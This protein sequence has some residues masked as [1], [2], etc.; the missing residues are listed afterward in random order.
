MKPNL[1]IVGAPKCGTTAWYEYLRGHPD[2]FL[3]DRKEPHYFCTDFPD[4]RRI[5]TERDYLG[6]FAEATSQPIAGEASAS[7]L[8]SKEAARNLR[9]FK[10][11]AKI[12]IF[13][14]NRPE[15]L[16]SWHNQLLDNGVENHADFETAWRLSGKRG[17]GDHGPACDEKSFL[18]YRAFGFLGEQVDRYFDQFPADQVRVFDFE[19]WR[20]DPRATYCEIMRFLGVRDG[21]RTDFPRINQAQRSRSKWL[22]LILHRPPRGL[23]ALYRAIR[24]LTGLDAAPLASLVARL[25][26]KRGY[27]ERL[28]PTLRAELDRLYAADEA[29]LR[30]RIWRA[31]K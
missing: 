27:G 16:F 31:V 15:L 17:P 25:N 1:F 3:P 19:D 11:D 24:R 26:A 20:R 12:V 28:S 13:V 10:P 22:R 23:S 6:L 8:Y 21:G 29:K 30:P 2:I 7:Y 18:D 4:Q 5:R 9:E 14:R